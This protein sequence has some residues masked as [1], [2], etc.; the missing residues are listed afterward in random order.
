MPRVTFP[1][2][3]W[4]LTLSVVPAIGNLTLIL[5]QTYIKSRCSY[6]FKTKVLKINNG[7][8][9]FY[10]LRHWNVC[11]NGVSPGINNRNWSPLDICQ[12]LAWG[13]P[14]NFSSPSHLL[15]WAFFCMRFDAALSPCG[16]IFFDTALGCQHN[17][18]LC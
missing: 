13:M 4:L 8:G 15:L 14:S 2:P 18:Y 16:S 11:G 3:K 17:C 7:K 12:L 1:A 10:I 5:W 6:T 9:P